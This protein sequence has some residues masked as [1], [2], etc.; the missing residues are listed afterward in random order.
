MKRRRHSTS[1][2]M[3]LEKNRLECYSQGLHCGKH[4]FE[5][6][7]RHWI[8]DKGEHFIGVRKS[9]WNERLWAIPEACQL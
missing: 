6:N 1:F 9:S 2:S 3:P 5:F 7:D 8:G 4:V